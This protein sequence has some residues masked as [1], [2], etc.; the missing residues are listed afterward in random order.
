[1]KRLKSI[2]L[3]LAVGVIF[4]AADGL[5]RRGVDE[6]LRETDSPAGDDA[7]SRSTGARTPTAMTSRG[8][9]DPGGVRTREKLPPAVYFR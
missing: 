5:W 9:F 1:M 4:L 8:A 6:R 3:L 2:L 7:V